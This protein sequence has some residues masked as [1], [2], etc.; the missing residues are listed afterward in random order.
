MRSHPSHSLSGS[1][2]KTVRVWNAVAGELVTVLRGHEHVVRSIVVREKQV[3][4]GSWD[5]TVRVWS[6]ESWGCVKVGFGF[7]VWVWGLG[8]RV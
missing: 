7:R 3:Y 5:A 1:E 2:D 6:A 8:F 4:T